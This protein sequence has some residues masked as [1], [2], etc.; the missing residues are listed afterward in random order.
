MLANDD[1]L[2]VNRK[3]AINNLTRI[4]EHIGRITVGFKNFPPRTVPLVPNDLECSATLRSIQKL[5]L[6]ERLAAFVF[7]QKTPIFNFMVF[8]S[9]T[10]KR[11]IRV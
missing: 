4:S 9:M 1:L 6:S 2:G 10:L 5:V 8:G 3:L 7:F 11:Y